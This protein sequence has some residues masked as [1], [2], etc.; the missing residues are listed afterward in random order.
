MKF[1]QFS[2]VKRSEYPSMSLWTF[3]ETRSLLQLSLLL[4][5]FDTSIFSV[6]RRFSFP[7]QI[8]HSKT[9][10]TFDIS[11]HYEPSSLCHHH[12]L[13]KTKAFLSGSA[14]PK[15]LNGFLHTC[16]LYCTK[17]STYDFTNLIYILHPHSLCNATHFPA[18]N[19]HPQLEATHYL[20]T[21]SLRI[22]RR[23]FSWFNRPQDRFT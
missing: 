3:Y 11:P 15:A 21:P 20:F 1:N 2:F 6:T 22:H 9:S 16:R 4:R 7:D 8:H 10:L 18:S 14:H 17:R 13:E 19:F 5:R 23:F 12:C